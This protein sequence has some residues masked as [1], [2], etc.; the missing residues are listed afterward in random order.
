M[1]SKPIYND[2][3]NLYIF[4]QDT[5]GLS[6]IESDPTRDIKLFSLAVILSS[7]FMFNLTGNIDEEAIN[8]LS[9]VTHVVNNLVISADE[10]SEECN[11]NNQMFEPFIFPN[12][13]IQRMMI[14]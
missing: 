5:E 12:F 3:E 1:W 10:P 14:G 11:N 8:Q 7:Y 4:F 9:L 6:S 2:K 13:P